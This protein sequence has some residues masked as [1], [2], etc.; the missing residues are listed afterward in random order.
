MASDNYLLLIATM[1]LKNYSCIPS[2]IA[3]HTQAAIIPGAWQQVFECIWPIAK[4][5]AMKL[6][7]IC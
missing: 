5:A 4:Q 2:R 3:Y 6:I 7:Q 1:Q